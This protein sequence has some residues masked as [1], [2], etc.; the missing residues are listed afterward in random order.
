MDDTTNRLKSRMARHTLLM[1]SGCHEWQAKFYGD[2][3]G[4]LKVAGRMVLA[5]RLSYQLHHPG[6]DISMLCVLHECDNRKCINPAHLFLGDR[7]V[8]NKDRD[9]K[10]RNGYSK[11]TADEQDALRWVFETLRP[12]YT[13]GCRWFGITR[14]TAWRNVNGRVKTA[15]NGRYHKDA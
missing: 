1:P 5:H 2:G 7:V 12:S 8:N 14:A 11:L 9:R 4:R 15:R 10:G 13:V 3:Y 6:V